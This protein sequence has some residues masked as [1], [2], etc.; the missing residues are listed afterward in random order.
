VFVI[1]GA[2]RIVGERK[3]FY[4]AEAGVVIY[5]VL[6][7]GIFGMFVLWTA[8]QMLHSDLER[9]R[10]EDDRERFFELSLDMLGVAGMDG[11][12]T[13]INPAFARTLG[14][15]PAEI[16]SRPFMDFVHPDDVLRTE[17]EMEK[18]GRGE[19]TLHFENRYQC[20]DGTWKWLEWSTRPYLEEG[21][22]YAVARDVSKKK[23]DEEGM[24]LLNE[25]LMEKTVM[26]EALNRELESF[27]YSVSHD[28]RAPLRSIAG[29]A[30]ALEDHCGDSLD[31]IAKGHLQRVRNAAGRMGELIDD[32]LDLS[33]LSRTELKATDVDL[34][35]MSLELLQQYQQN[36]PARNVET[37]VSP[38]IRVRGDV[39]LLR[40]LLDNLLGN[41][42]K[43]TSKNP[44]ARI[45]LDAVTRDGRVTCSVKDNGVGFD[46]RYAHK[47]FGA[48]QRLHA[49]TEFKGTGIGLA[50]VERIVRRHG[51]SATAVGVVGQGAVIE[52]ILDAIDREVKI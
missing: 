21:F 39:A 13:Q 44:A 28:L 50:T 38:G 3:D 11:Y 52:F 37:V 46:M 31:P 30:L 1:A 51:G 9:Q 6:G 32:L 41:A 22:L 24:K 19:S 26:L 25:E 17:T 23:R 49:Q 18:L 12:F 8:K 14:R 5:T 33:R 2:L 36:E 27:S 7:I 35:A 16:L 20:G 40:V 48:F 4:Q 15:E 34:S 10:V 42:W 45:E 47:L 43:F 29:F